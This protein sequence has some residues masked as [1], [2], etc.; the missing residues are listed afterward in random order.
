MRL[1]EP[2]SRR[3]RPDSPQKENKAPAK[4][5]WAQNWAQWKRADWRIGP[6]LLVRKGGLE[7]PRFYPPDPKSGASANSATF[8]TLMDYTK[9]P[10]L[11]RRVYRFESR[12]NREDAHGYGP[13]RLPEPQQR[14]WSSVSPSRLIGHNSAP[15]A[16]VVKLR[17]LLPLATRRPLLNRVQPL[18]DE[19]AQQHQQQHTRAS[20]EH[21]DRLCQAVYFHQQFGL[22]L[23]H[24]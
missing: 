12:L 13:P 20:A 7:P 14:S 15:P 2:S 6:N 22:L 4:S 19:H 16:A 21:P 10:R 17:A 24:V 5:R 3:R 9:R 1:R 8:A 11:P 18:I 23:L